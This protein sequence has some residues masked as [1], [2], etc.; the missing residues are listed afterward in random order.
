M[1]FLKIS[2]ENANQESNSLKQAHK[3]WQTS[4]F[5]NIAS[6]GTFFIQLTCLMRFNLKISLT[7]SRRGYLKRKRREEESM[8]MQLPELQLNDHKPT[9]TNFVTLYFLFF[10]QLFLANPRQYKILRG[11]E[12]LNST[13][14]SW[15]LGTPRHMTIG[16]W[17]CNIHT[18]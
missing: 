18:L 3:D 7:H 2:K 15:D 16:N 17:H 11:E 12:I 4:I 1:V 14:T 10:S 5:F 6:F 8:Q 9:R 13:R